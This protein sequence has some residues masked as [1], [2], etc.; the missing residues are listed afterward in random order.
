MRWRTWCNS[1]RNHC[2]KY[3]KVANICRYISGCRIK[4]RVKI[5]PAVCSIVIGDKHLGSI[6]YAG[7]ITMYRQEKRLT[8][9]GMLQACVADI[10]YQCIQF[11]HGLHRVRYGRLF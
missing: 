9:Y 7:G 5:H 6:R 4:R 3:G 11:A 10:G 1:I 8:E 2:G